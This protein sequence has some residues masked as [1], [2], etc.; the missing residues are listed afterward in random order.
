[1][2]FWSTHKQTSSG[3]HITPITT[4][5]RLALLLCGG[6]LMLSL[7]SCG[8]APATAPVDANTAP[9]QLVAEDLYTTALRSTSQGPLM[10]GSLQP[11]VKAE[12][13]A[14]VAG[15]VLKVLKDNGDVVKA[16]DVLIQLDPTIVRDKWLSAQEA[17]RSAALALTQAERQLKRLSGLRQQNMVTADQLEAA[18]IKFNQAQS[19]VASAKARLVEARQQM[20]KT[21]VRAPFSGVV[22]S[23]K[24]FAGDTVQIGKALMVLMDPKSMR[25]EGFIPAEHVGAIA[26]GQSVSFRVNGYT[27]RFNGVIQRINPQAN[28][29]TRQVQLFVTIDDAPSG[30]VAGLYAEGY[31]DVKSQSAILVPPSLVTTEGDNHFV[32]RVKDQHLQK[33]SVTLGAHDHRTGMVEIRQG[34][35]ANE[36]LLRHPI[37]QLRDGAAVTVMSASRTTSAEAQEPQA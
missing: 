21:D 3:Q 9:L 30:L 1:M 4:S 37:G 7:I 18:E 11:E 6:V 8:K 27:Q 35:A 20:D 23:R 32:W 34:V 5:V 33:V 28:E 14:E 24:A 29:M 15:I 19:D 22:A 31:V 13:N 26:V 16:G 36:Q 12:M 17:E 2:R 25:F 10:S